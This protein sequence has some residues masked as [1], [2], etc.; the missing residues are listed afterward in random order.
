MQKQPAQRTRSFQF[1][2]P[3]LLLGVMAFCSLLSIGALFDWSAVYLSGTL[4]TGVGLAAAGFTAFLACMAIG[5]SAGDVLA[6]RFGA[7]VLVRIACLLAA[8]GL[9]LALVFAWVPAALFG[10]CLV[11]IGLSVPLPLVLSAAARLAKGD[12]GSTL[13]TV[14]TWGYFGMIVGPSMIGFI[15]DRLGMRLALAPIVLLCIAAALCASVTG[16]AAVKEDE[17]SSQEREP[18]SSLR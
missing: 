2:S 12:K 10:L 16:T 9:A 1:S 7:T 8:S 15:A 14:T 5:R 18:T 11:G 3:L 13:A 4:H 17:V 6:T